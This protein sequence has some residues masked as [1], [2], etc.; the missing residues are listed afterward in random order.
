MEKIF[1]QWNLIATAVYGNIGAVPDAHGEKDALAFSAKGESPV[2]FARRVSVPKD[3]QPRLALRL[4]HEPGHNHRLVVRLGNKI[5][6]EENY[7]WAKTPQVW[8]DINVDLIMPRRF[9]A[10]TAIRR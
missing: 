8:S 10:R 6:H 5:V 4:G 3:G 7:E 1:P 2:V 9:Y